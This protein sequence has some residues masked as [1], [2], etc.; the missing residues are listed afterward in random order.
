MP[1]EQIAWKLVTIIGIIIVMIIIIFF[2]L[3]A[4]G[5]L[6]TSAF[7]PI[8]AFIDKYLS[9]GSG[10]FRIGLPHVGQN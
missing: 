9:I 3:K 2:A 10:W 5:F 1:A 7:Q 8:N 6:S 4:S